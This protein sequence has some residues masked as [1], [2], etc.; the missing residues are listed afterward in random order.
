[1]L[2]KSLLSKLFFP[3]SPNPLKRKYFFSFLFIF[4]GVRLLT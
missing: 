2:K 4:L 3:L 1:M